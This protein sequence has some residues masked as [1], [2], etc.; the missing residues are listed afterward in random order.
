M[1]HEHWT[2]DGCGGDLAADH[3][4]L[5]GLGAIGAPSD[6]L[7]FPCN[8]ADGQRD[9]TVVVRFAHERDLC[10]ACKRAIVLD[11]L[12]GMRAHAEDALAVG[13]PTFGTI[14]HKELADTMA[15]ARESLVGERLAVPRGLCAKRVPGDVTGLCDQEFGH[16][17]T[18]EP[19][20]PFPLRPMMC[21]HSALHG[22]G[23]DVNYCAEPE[24]HSGRHRALRDGDVVKW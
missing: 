3:G 9:A 4:E 5:R 23:P 20:G 17:G 24:G 6:E 12:K 18:C 21:P 11:G 22:C 19:V 8:A 7:M 2:C 1:K 13:A 16:K 14:S 15:G 10:N